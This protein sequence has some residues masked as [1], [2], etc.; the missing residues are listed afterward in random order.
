M[1]VGWLYGW[2]MLGF[3]SL[4]AGNPFVIIWFDRNFPITSVCSTQ[5][6]NFLFSE[7]SASQLEQ[8]QIWYVT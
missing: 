5:G 1:I 8:G 7:F 3:I 6:P 4:M 2:F